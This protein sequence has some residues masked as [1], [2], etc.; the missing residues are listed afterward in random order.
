MVEPLILTYQ[1]ALIIE[2]K[3][4]PELLEEERIMREKNIKKEQNKM[5]L[6]DYDERQRMHKAKIKQQMGIQ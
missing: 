3:I 6:F 4:Q 5:E 2:E 1:Y